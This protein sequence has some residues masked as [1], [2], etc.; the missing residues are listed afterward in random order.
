MK[1]DL[2][3]VDAFAREAFSGNPA[4]VVPLEN[5]LSDDLMQKIANENNL[6][7]T[8]FFVKENKLYN[9][10]WFT[11]VHE[12]NLCGHATL[13]SACVLFKFIETETE[14]LHFHSKSGP[15]SVRKVGEDSFQLNFPTDD[16]HAQPLSE[17]MLDGLDVNPVKIMKGRD[18]Y[19][20]ELASQSEVEALNPSFELLK[21]TEARGFL[22]T[23]KGNSVDVV[24]RGFF[25]RSGVN[26]DP[27]TGSAVTSITPFWAKKL[28][29]TDLNIHQLSQR[30]GYFKSILDNDRTLI[31]GKAHL[32]LKGEIYI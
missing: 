10:R 28:N 20:I 16:L 14:E 12:V 23:A 19:L 13:A 4:A 8:A 18:D 2:Y 25:P 22:V 27:A 7:E 3:Q 17:S 30:V 11:P 5:W 1:L 29:K 21:A 6:S 32:Y 31:T 9:I 15:L 24:F 26:E